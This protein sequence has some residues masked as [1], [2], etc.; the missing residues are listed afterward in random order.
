MNGFTFDGVHSDDLG[1]IVNKKNVP[2]SPPVNGRTQT[3]DGFDGAWDYGVS[4]D[5]REIDL[6]CTIFKTEKRTMKDNLRQIVKAFNPRK[7][8]KKLVFDDEPDKCYFARLDAQVP[9]EQKGQMGTFTIELVCP[10]RP[11]TYGT[12]E[13]IGTFS[14]DLN[15]S[16]EGTHVAKP[17]LTITHNGGEGAVTLTR[18]DGN[19]LELALSSSSPSGEYVIDCTEY[20]IQ[21]NGEPAYQYVT[22]DYFEMDEGENSFVNSG[23]ISQ[24]KIAFRDT[25]I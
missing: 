17:T 18:N 16:H 12:D 10:E 5:P 2:M 11:H 7:G 9:L 23:N 25:W 20:T 1:V 22:G 3:I 8:A 13:R 15:T 14:N 19:I 21:K 6:E 4:Y 24:V